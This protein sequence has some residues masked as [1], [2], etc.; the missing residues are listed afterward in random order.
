VCFKAF[1]EFA[2]GLM[3]FLSDAVK[4]NKDLVYQ[5]MFLLEGFFEHFNEFF[6]VSVPKF[7]NNIFV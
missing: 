1:A 7:E 2:S 4:F 5:P 6:S 3:R